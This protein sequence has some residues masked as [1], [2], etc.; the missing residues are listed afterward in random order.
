MLKSITGLTLLM[1]LAALPLVGCHK[2][3]SMKG[4]E[5]AA[6]EQPAPPPDDTTLNNPGVGP[7]PIATNP[8]GNGGSGGSGGSGGNGGQQPAVPEPGTI[9]IVGLGLAAAHLA[10]RKRRRRR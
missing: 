1:T 6:T 4:A 10:S 3:G 8:G 5:P 7:G 9:A 2:G